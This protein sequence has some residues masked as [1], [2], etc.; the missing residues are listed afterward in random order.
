M[1]IKVYSTV[2][3]VTKLK[4]YFEGLKVKLFQEFIRDPKGLKFQWDFGIAVH[5]FG[6]Q[7]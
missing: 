4:W 3:H 6:W 7:L 1:Y 5:I 2:T